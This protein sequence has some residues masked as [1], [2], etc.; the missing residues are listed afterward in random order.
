MMGGSGKRSL[1]LA[2]AVRLNTIGKLSDSIVK[3]NLPK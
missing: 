1:P 2:R 3:D